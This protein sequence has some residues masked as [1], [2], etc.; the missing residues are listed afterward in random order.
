[1]LVSLPLPVRVSLPVQVQV[2]QNGISQSTVELGVLIGAQH[3]I[4]N[5]GWPE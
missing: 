1:M 4:A 2:K 5:Q 3:V